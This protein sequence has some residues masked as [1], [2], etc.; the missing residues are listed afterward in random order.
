MLVAYMRDSHPF[1]AVLFGSCLSMAAAKATRQTSGDLV[2]NEDRTINQSDEW[3]WEW[4]KADPK[5][6]ARRSQAAGVKVGALE[7]NSTRRPEPERLA[8]YR[9]PYRHFPQTRSR[10]V[11]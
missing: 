10:L 5:C 4:E 2:F 6:Y 1:D 3:L 8:R 9:A 11:F 7:V